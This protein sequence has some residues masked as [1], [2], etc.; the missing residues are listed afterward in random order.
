MDL[1]HVVFKN[2]EN[3]KVFELLSKLTELRAKLKK[4]GKK[5]D[6]ISTRN[7]EKEYEVYFN[8]MVKRFGYI[9]ELHTKRYMKYPNYQ[10]LLQE[11]YLGLV[12]ALRKFDMARSNNFFKL[13]NWYVKTRVKRAANKFDVVNVPMA[14]GKECPPCRVDIPAVLSDHSEFEMDIIDTIQQSEM[15]RNALSTL[16]H[17]SKQVICYFYG[18]DFSGEEIFS[19][20]KKSIED[21]SKEMKLPKMKIK[22]IIETATDNLEMIVE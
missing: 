18:I 21:I 12:V 22:K 20:E 15:I 9:A 3:R 17:E 2:E 5:T 19:A 11:G 6:V 1:D 10:D 4:K 13:A 14:V 16:P 8:S 7:A